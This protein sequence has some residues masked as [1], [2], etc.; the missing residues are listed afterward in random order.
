MPDQI[1]QGYNQKV[2]FLGP[3][4]SRRSNFLSVTTE[5]L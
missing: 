4:V 1:G 5:K 3:L 2:H